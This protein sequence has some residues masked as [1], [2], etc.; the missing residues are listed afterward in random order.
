MLVF[1]VTNQ[2][3]FKNLDYW[4]EEIEKYWIVLNIEMGHLA[5]KKYS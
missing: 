2:E 5:A 1:D 3:S 4:L